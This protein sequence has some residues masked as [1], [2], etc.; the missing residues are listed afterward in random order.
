M[1]WGSCDQYVVTPIILLNHS[2]HHFFLIL[3]FMCHPPTVVCDAVRAADSFLILSILVMILQDRWGLWWLDQLAYV[4]GWSRCQGRRQLGVL[5]GWRTGRLMYPSS[6][7]FCN[8]NYTFMSS[9][10]LVNCILASTVL[11][12]CLLFLMQTVETFLNCDVPFRHFFLYSLCL[13]WNMRNF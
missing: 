3:L 5:V 8:I 4:Q 10:V 7:K 12:T 1:G 2:C 9:L 6:C 11:P 13:K